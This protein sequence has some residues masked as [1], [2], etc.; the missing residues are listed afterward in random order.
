MGDGRSRSGFVTWACWPLAHVGLIL[1][2]RLFH[3]HILLHNRHHRLHLATAES[4]CSAGNR[5]RQDSATN[6]S[7]S[8]NQH[9]TVFRGQC[10]F[11]GPKATLVAH[12]VSSGVSSCTS[13]HHLILRYCALCNIARRDYGRPIQLALSKRRL[14]HIHFTLS[15]TTSTPEG[16]QKVST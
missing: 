12:S 13:L 10:S 15:P 2:L 11:R 14:L 8:R 5:D 16:P 6:P 1:P 4:G 7:P 3:P 9:L